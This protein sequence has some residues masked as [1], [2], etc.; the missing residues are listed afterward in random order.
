M[1]FPI[2]PELT[3]VTYLSAT[4]S[5]AA[6]AATAT[7]AGTATQ[8]AYIT[9]FQV[10][11]TGATTQTCINVTVLGIQGTAAGHSGTMTYKFQV[12]TGGTAAATPLAVNFTPPYPAVAAGSAITVDIQSFGSGNLHSAVT[13]QGFRR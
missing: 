11:G 4:A 1:S 5:A 9:G 2:N 10:T 6:A 7:I 13:A 12:P 8:L 3:G